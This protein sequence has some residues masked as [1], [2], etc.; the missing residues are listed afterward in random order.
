MGKT[1][2]PQIRFKGFDGEWEEKKLGEIS[3]KVSTKNI[4]GFITLT[5]TNSAEFGIIN[6]TDFFDKEISN[7]KNLSGYYVVEPDDFVYNPRISNN[8]P[9][10]PINRNKLNYSGVMSPLYYVFRV[11]ETNL[12]FLEYVFRTRVWHPFMFLNGN[13]GARSDRF[14]ISENVFNQMPLN[15]PKEDAEQTKI[16]NLLTSVDKQISLQ[17]QKIEKL[18]AIKKTLLKKMFV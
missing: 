7:K 9:V 11:R 5:L 17:E 6:Q 2:I 3:N 8:A 13:S 1:H 16:A 4:N 14:S 10:G 15:I 12:T 18:K